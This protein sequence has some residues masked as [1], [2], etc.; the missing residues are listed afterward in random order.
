MGQ[1]FDTYIILERET[2]L[3]IID[4][5]AAHERILFDELMKNLQNPFSQPL[6]IPYKAKLSAQEF[7]YMETIAPALSRLGFELSFDQESTEMEISALPALIS[8]I[9]LDEFFGYFLRESGDKKDAELMGEKDISISELLIEKIAKT[10][11][12][13]AIRG[14]DALSE[15]QI[16]YILDVFFDKDLNL[17]KKCPHGRPAVIELSRSDLE[18]MFK[19]KL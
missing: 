13:S 17:P 18:K 8:D 10:A 19:R 14:G 2:S 11:C 6:L 3:Y 15:N 1:I 12:K 5:H 16:A 4:Q 9:K 7:E